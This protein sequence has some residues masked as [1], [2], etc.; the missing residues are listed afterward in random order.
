MRWNDGATWNDLLIWTDSDDMAVISATST[1]IPISRPIQI[2]TVGLIRSMMP[3]ELM[4]SG[5]ITGDVE[6]TGLIP[7]R[8][9][10]DKIIILNTTAN[11][12]QISAGT[13]AGGFQ[14]FTSHAIA[15]SGETVISIAKYISTLS[16]VFLH[17]DGAGDVWNS[18]SLSIY[19]INW[20]L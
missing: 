19:L 11:A 8:T 10:I 20:K 4:A 15:A 9:Y 14:L 16:S 6:L 13:S 5:E 7:D 12:G 18:M 17:D 3:S 1:T 2:D